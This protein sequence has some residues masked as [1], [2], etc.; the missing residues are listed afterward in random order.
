MPPVIPDLAPSVDALRAEY[1]RT[2]G[3][4]A[5]VDEEGEGEGKG[6]GEGEGEAT[7]EFDPDTLYIAIGCADSTVVY[8]KLSRGIRK[9]HDIPDE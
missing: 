8:Y 9:P 5:Q 6:E 7:D 1:A 4:M 3:E 2:P